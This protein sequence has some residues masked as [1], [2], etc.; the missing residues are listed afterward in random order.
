MLCSPPHLFFF[1]GFVE[2][3]GGK[4]QGQVERGFVH[5]FELVDTFRHF[6]R[7]SAGATLL[8]QRFFLR[9]VFKFLSIGATLVGSFPNFHVA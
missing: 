6:P 2:D 5:F 3:G 8:F 9:S 4:H 7:D 1:S